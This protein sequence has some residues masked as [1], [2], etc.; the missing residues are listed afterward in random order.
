MNDLGDIV[1]Q[2]V[3]ERVDGP[4]EDEI[5]LWCEA[6]Y[7]GLFSAAFQVLVSLKEAKGSREALEQQLKSMIE[8]TA[9]HA[10]VWINA[11]LTTTLPTGQRIEFN[12]YFRDSEMLVLY[13]NEA[14]SVI[15]EGGYKLEVGRSHACFVV[16]R[17]R[18]E[19]L[20]AAGASFDIEAFF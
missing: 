5:D 16:L 2:F 20:V 19:A 10:S 6:V 3:E 1:S 9:Q 17:K 13:F 11:R 18:I 15:T 4:R 14:L 7:A 8:S 12:L